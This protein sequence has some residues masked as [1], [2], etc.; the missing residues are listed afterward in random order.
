MAYLIWI[1]QAEFNHLVARDSVVEQ[2]NPL[3]AILAD[4]APKHESLMGAD[5]SDIRIDASPDPYVVEL[6]K[7]SRQLARVRSGSYFMP[8]F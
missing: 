8:M 6:H 4:W 7:Q 2:L 3:D 5:P 1:P